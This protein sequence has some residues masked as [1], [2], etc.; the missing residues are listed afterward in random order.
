MTATYERTFRKTASCPSCQSL[1]A[2]GRGLENDDAAFIKAHLTGCD[3]C[4][5]ELQLL[6]RL[7]SSDE[8]YVFVEMPTPLRSLAETSLRRQSLQ[9]SCEPRNRMQSLLR[10][11]S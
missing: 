5:A 1:L 2:Y 8:E 3:F 6:S 9:C 4:A 11:A 10:L 7:D